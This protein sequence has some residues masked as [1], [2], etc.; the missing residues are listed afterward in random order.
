VLGGWYDAA[1]YD[2]NLRHY[3]NIFDMLYAYELAPAK[4]SDNMLNIPE[5]GNGIP[6]L[7]DEAEYG[8]DVWTRS[9][10]ADGGVSGR[11]ETNSHPTLTDTNFNWSP[12]SIP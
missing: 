2:R 9:M 10:T 1:D 11:L 12:P 7:L 6:D 3:T 5:S 4:F 8:L